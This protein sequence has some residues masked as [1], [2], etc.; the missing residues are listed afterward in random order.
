VFNKLVLFGDIGFVVH[1]VHAVAA[2]E[3]DPQ[4]R[5]R[6]VGEASRVAGSP[7]VGDGSRHIDR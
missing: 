6:H 7:L 5:G 4:R 3:P 1:D 2:D